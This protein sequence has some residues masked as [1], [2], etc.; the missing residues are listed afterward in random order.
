MAPVPRRADDGV[1]G[2]EEV[3]EGANVSA[4]ADDEDKAARRA[5]APLVD[6]NEAAEDGDMRAAVAAATRLPEEETTE[7]NMEAVEGPVPA[8]GER[9]MGGK[10]D[11]N[12]DEVDEEED[13]DAAAVLARARREAVNEEEDDA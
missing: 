1:C 3:D 12:A 13:D 8:S 4:D 5:P 2:N 11:K 9:A 7:L 10:P 6:R